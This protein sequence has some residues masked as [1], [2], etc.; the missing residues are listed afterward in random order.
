MRDERIKEI[1]EDIADIS[2]HIAFKE[3]RHSQ[4]EI[5]QNYTL[6]HV[7]ALCL[8][9]HRKAIMGMAIKTN[10]L[11]C[12]SKLLTYFLCCKHLVIPRV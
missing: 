9:L 6:L 10:L 8:P 12:S 3:K 7:E 4:A 1:E 2:S 5:G 11:S